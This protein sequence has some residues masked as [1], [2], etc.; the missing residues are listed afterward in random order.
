MSNFIEKREVIFME[1][2][3]VVEEV[4][5]GLNWKERIIVFVFKKFCVKLYKNGITFGFNNK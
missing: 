2:D 1:K 3:V 4:K 5:K